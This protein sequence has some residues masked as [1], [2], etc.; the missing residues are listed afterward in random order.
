MSSNSPRLLKEYLDEWL[1][2]QREA[3]AITSEVERARAAAEWQVA[4]YP[5]IQSYLPPSL[6][7]ILDARVELAY[8]QVRIVLPMPPRY[9]PLT[10]TSVS[11]AVATGTM[12]TYGFGLAFSTTASPPPEVV[13]RHLTS[14]D[15]LQAAQDRGAT[16][17]T[18]LQDV[19]LALAVQFDRAR[20]NQLT[21]RS[22]PDQ[23]AGAALE[24]RTLLDNLRGELFQKARIS[25][26]E[27]MTWEIMSDRLGT[28][29]EVSRELL[30]E[31]KQD[32][33]RLLDDL[34]AIAK[35]RQGDRVSH[36][37]DLWPLVLEHLYVTCSNVR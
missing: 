33:S 19:S 35:R 1:A 28:R 29:T 21:A 12:G 13:Q 3:Q 11:S 25:P 36:L 31:Q 24:I 27:N 23:A 2:R 22:Q 18:L 20:G 14:F 9:E 8:K 30:L 34:S 37:S 16:V 17:R 5:D 15:R 32:R 7:Q 26:G 10:G 4:A 6:R